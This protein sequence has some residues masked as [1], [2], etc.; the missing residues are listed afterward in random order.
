MKRPNKPLNIKTMFVWADGGQKDALL[1]RANII[2]KLCT[3]QKVAPKKTTQRMRPG[4]GSRHTAHLM[5]YPTA[6]FQT[7]SV[8]IH[9]GSSLHQKVFF[10][11]SDGV[12]CY[13]IHA[14]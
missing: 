12:Y 2:K 7:L 13:L 6:P 9:P 14:Y 8:E 3:K 5:T 11:A 1:R 4:S 10:V